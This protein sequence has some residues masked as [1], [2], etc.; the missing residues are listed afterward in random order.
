MKKKLLFCVFA[1]VALVT[2]VGCGSKDDSNSIVGTWEYE[3]NSQYVYKFNK[4]KTGSYTAYGTEMKFTYEDKGTE[5]S[6]LYDGNTN[7][8]TFEY[9][10][11]KNKLI[12]NDS[13]GSE[14][15]YIKK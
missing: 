9:R 10:I 7:A 1:F 4:D 5:V 14:V 15:T 6:I 2:L 11:E 3:T 12:I 8:S 13:F